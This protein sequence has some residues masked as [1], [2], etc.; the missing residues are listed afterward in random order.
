MKV[1]GLTY[2]ARVRPGCGPIVGAAP[3]LAM[4][5]M[6]AALIL[7]IVPAGGGCGSGGSVSPG[8][9]SPDQVAVSPFPADLPPSWLPAPAPAGTG[10]YAED[11]DWIGRWPQLSEASPDR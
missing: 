2:P 11:L 10:N 1:H 5:W 4:L 3:V 6:L 9:D 8:N 7:G